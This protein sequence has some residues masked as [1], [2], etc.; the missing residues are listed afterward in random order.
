MARLLS[1]FNKEKTL[2]QRVKDIQKGNENDKNNLIEEY[3]PFIKKVISNELG[4]Y[5]DIE[6]NDAFSIGL[7]AFDEAIKRYNEKRGNFLTFASVVIK[8]RLIDY[9]RSCARKPKEIYISELKCDDESYGY[10][11]N[12]IALDSFEKRVEIRYDITALVKEMKNYGVSLED[13]IKESPKHKDTRVTA[14]S[15]GRYIFENDYLKEKFL[16][17]RNLPVNDLTR[18]LCVSKKVLKR[19]RKFIIAIV[20]IL[21]SDLDTLKEYIFYSKGCELNGLQRHC[22]G[23]LS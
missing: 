11:E 21:N 19:S 10:N 4:Q 8:S 15:I 23:D 6:N 5:V 20:L 16:K 7:I 2:E 14:I 22:D 18:Q 1:I 12:I 3:I 13:L 9:L 17:T